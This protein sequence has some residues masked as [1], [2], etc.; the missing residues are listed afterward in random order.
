NALCLHQL[1]WDPAILREN[2]VTIVI[3]TKNRADLLA[4][5]LDS[6]ARTTPR[7]FVKI[8]L[9][10]DSSDDPAALDFLTAQPARTDLRIEVITAPPTADGFNY[11]RL[12]NLGTARADTPL[13]LHLN[14][15]VTALNPGWLE[16]MAG[17]LSLPEV[18]VVGAK[19]LYPDGTLNHAGISVSHEDG[20][21]HVL[22]EKEPQD[23]FG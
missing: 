19:L 6:L 11:S 10:D 13:V 23:D 21:P 1:K 7:E 15:D 4:P 22:F 3:P 2:P 5:C 17:W 16:D 12:V 14:N 20:L 8:V 18:G 9:V